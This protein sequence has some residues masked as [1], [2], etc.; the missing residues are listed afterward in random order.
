[1]IPEL[2]SFFDRFKE[3]STSYSKIKIHFPKYFKCIQEV[4]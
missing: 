1:M 2:I 3:H 4:I